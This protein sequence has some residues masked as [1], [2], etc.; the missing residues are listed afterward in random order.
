MLKHKHKH[1]IMNKVFTVCKFWWMSCEINVFSIVYEVDKEST[2]ILYF[3]FNNLK[4]KNSHILIRHNLEQEQDNSQS[5][6]KL[7][8]FH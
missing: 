6:S 4:S 8:L 2:Y 7:F 3:L 1:V 5:Q